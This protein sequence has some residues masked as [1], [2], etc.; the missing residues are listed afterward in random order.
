MGSHM[1]TR[2]FAAQRNLVSATM[3]EV[4][5][6]CPSVVNPNPHPTN[7]QLVTGLD[8]CRIPYLKL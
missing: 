6:P 8:L 7:L 5:I 1:L 3:C 4:R 2:N